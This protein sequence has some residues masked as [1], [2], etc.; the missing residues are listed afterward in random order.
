MKPLGN[1]Y[2]GETDKEQGFK[3]HFKS[4]SLDDS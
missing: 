2:D 4:P 1:A 3:K